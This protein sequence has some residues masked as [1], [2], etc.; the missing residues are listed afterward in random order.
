M[1]PRRGKATS[2]GAAPRYTYSHNQLPATLWYHDHLMG[3][4]GPHVWFGMAG[5][6]ILTDDYEDGLGLPSGAYE[7]PLVIQDRNFDSTGKLVS[8]GS[9]NGETGNAILVK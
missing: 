5:F 4:T 9:R 6:Y 8:P 1:S 7:I 3:Y 2:P